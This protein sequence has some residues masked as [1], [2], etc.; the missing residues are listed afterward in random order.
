MRVSLLL[1]VCPLFS[2][3]LAFVYP[4]ITNTPV[5]QVEEPDV[6]AFRVVSGVIQSGPW[7]TGPID[8]Y[9]TVETLPTKDNAIASQSNTYFPYYYLAFPVAE[10]AHHRSLEIL[11]YRR[12]Y[13]TVSIPAVSWLRF[14]EHMARPQWKKAE[15]LEDVEKA[16]ETITP[17]RFDLSRGSTEVRQ[18]VA[19]EYTWLADSEWVTGP[20]R[21]TVRQRLL[22]K[23]K[24]PESK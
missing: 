20:E 6:H 7:M 4:S 14:S 15:Q 24:N 8:F 17:S 1:L 19:Q 5:I 3:C 12:G 21:E 2:G 23:A 18:F 16:I 9:E 10:G 13:E 22:E 11:L